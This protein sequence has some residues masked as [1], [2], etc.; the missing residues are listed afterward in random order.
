MKEKVYLIV[1]DASINIG[2]KFSLLKKVIKRN[3]YQKN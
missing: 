2:R 1:S 3:K